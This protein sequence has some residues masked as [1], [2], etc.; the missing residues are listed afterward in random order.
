MS[1]RTG[2]QKRR[3]DDREGVVFPSPQRLQRR[4][5]DE[6]VASWRQRPSHTRNVNPDRVGR[7]LGHGGATDAILGD[8]QH[9]H[10]P[11]KEPHGAHQVYPQLVD[12]CEA[13]PVVDVVPATDNGED[14]EKDVKDQKHFVRGAKKPQDAMEQKNDQ[15]EVATM[16]QIQ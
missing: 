1:V 10:Q 3:W 11:V 14:G 16:P 15:A 7:Y 2:P 8:A 5:E 13:L 6:R 12:T 9:T 4:K